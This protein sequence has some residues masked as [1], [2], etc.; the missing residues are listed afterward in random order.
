M[1]KKTIVLIFFF[2]LITSEGLTETLHQKVEQ[3]YGRDAIENYRNLYH[4]GK[5]MP[6]KTQDNPEDG[7]PSAK[8]LKSQ[9]VEKTNSLNPKAKTMMESAIE[10]QE[11]ALESWGQV[12]K[13]KPIFDM[14]K[15]VEK[16][17]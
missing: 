3:K 11:K 16:P 15:N 1:N 4:P 10:G 13:N 17:K 12:H 7:E 9:T 5:L 2:A 6:G 8:A 14:F